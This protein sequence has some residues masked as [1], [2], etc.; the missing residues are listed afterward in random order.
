LSRSRS[1]EAPHHEIF[2]SLCHFLPFLTSSAFVHTIMRQT[3]FH[4]HKKTGKITYLFILIFTFFILLC[5]YIC[6]CDAEK[7]MN[8]Y[9]YIFVYRERLELIFLVQLVLLSSWSPNVDGT[10]MLSHDHRIQ[11]HFS[12]H[13]RKSSCSTRRC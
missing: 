12:P 4:T 7:N 13:T 5:I 3:K 1:G 10:I 6:V 8:N 9:L 2:S 11:N